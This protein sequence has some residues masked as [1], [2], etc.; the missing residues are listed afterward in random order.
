MGVISLG[1]MA[2]VTVYLGIYAYNNPDPKACW[3]VRDLHTSGVT[4]SDVI[5]RA[6]S[7]GIDIVDGYPLEMHKVY[8]VWFLWGFWAQIIC[9]VLTAIVVPLSFYK[10]N[11]ASVLG[12]IFFGLYC[13]NSFVWL[14]FGSI[15]RFSKAGVVASGDKLERLYGT[16]D[17]LWAKSLE[18]AQVSNG[19]QVNS[20]RF[21]KIYLML[22]AWLII[23]FLLG[24]IVSSL[25]MCCCDPRSVKGHNLKEQRNTGLAQK[26][27][28]NSAN[29]FE[30]EDDEENDIIQPQKASKLI[31][32]GPGG[33]SY[34]QKYK[35]A[36]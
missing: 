18:A 34:G 23:I 32:K 21:M 5:A 36:I 14:A 30:I 26:A 4:K 31:N 15:W 13:T 3:V 2:T 10:Q 9:I 29:E 12:S 7:M 28:F 24:C 27:G 16:T 17:A 20:G 33:Q 8:V 1:V 6:N 25:V 35:N 11:L 19:Y 22:M